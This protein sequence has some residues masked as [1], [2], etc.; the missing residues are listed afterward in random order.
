MCLLLEKRRKQYF[1]FDISI[2]RRWLNLN[3][4]SEKC[5]EPLGL[6]QFS[7]SSFY[8]L[9]KSSALQDS[10]PAF[11]LRGGARLKA[12]QSEIYERVGVWFAFFGSEA[13]QL[14]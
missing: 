11:Q 13:R 2:P 1:F 3:V 4:R 7:W 14:K 10:N 9:A 12:A 8:F 5:G 6:R